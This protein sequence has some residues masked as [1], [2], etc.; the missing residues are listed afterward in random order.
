MI[1]EKNEDFGRDDR[2]FHPEEQQIYWERMQNRDPGLNEN[3]SNYY[4]TQRNN[5]T[6]SDSE[7]NKRTQ[8]D[9]EPELDRDLDAALDK[10]LDDYSDE[11][12]D[13]KDQSDS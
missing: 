11:V 12:F 6:D 4:E 7:N 1:E 13:K 2:D 9:I 8:Q 3:D 5:T 10:E